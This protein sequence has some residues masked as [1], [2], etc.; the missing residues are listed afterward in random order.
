MSIYMRDIPK[1]LAFP[2][3]CFALIHLLPY[4]SQIKTSGLV[5]HG[6]LSKYRTILDYR[7]TNEKNVSPDCA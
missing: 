2:P 7:I 6:V 4:S 5:L 1:A 3:R